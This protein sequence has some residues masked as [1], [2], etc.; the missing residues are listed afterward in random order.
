MPAVRIHRP[1]VATPTPVSGTGWFSATGATVR[2]TRAR[3]TDRS[4]AGWTRRWTTGPRASIPCPPPVEAPGGVV[5]V[6][7]GV[8]GGRAA[9]SGRA[10]LAVLAVRYGEEDPRA[11]RRGAD[12]R[13][14][15]DRHRRHRG[16][17]REHDRDHAEHVPSHR[18]ASV[19]E[20]PRAGTSSCTYKESRRS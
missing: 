6:G 13:G 5:G 2:R 15:R 14:P 20:V 1:P 8:G 7:L 17:H 11:V 10:V 4:T 12:R 16:R 3:L 9:R 19:S 18:R